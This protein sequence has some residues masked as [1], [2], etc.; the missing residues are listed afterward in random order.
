MIS[1]AEV[2]LTVEV[3]VHIGDEVASITR[4][5]D[6]A[7]F[8]LWMVEQDTEQFARRITCAAY[9]TYSDHLLSSLWIP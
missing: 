4:G 3:F 9:D 8:C 2:S 6:E 7:D 5:L 1:K